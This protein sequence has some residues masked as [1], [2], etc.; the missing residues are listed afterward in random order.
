MR[1]VVK[2]HGVSWSLVVTITEVAYNSS[3]NYS[4]GII[5][6]GRNPLNPF[7]IVPFPISDHSSSDAKHWVDYHQYIHFQVR[8]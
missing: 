8:K 2:K 7:D 1:I 4:V 6:Y 3:R 5:V